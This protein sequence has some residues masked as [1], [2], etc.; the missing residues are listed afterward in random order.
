MK[1]GPALSKRLTCLYD[2]CVLAGEEAPYILCD[3]GC[4]HAHV[5]IRLLGSG[6]ITRAICMDVIPGPL[7]KAKEN[8]TL[9]GCED[10]ADLILSDGLQ[11]YPGGADV[12]L[13]SGMGG[14][15]MAQILLAEPEKVLSFRK[16]ILQPQSEFTALRKAL[17]QLSIRIEDEAMVEEEGKFYPVLYASPFKENESGAAALS[18]IELEYGPV[19]L[20]KKD[21]VLKR[22]LENGLLKIRRILQG[23]PADGKDEERASLLHTKEQIE[24][25][26]FL[27]SEKEG[28]GQ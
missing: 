7:Q 4:D 9:Y 11:Q 8:L 24:Q 18:D 26:L 10:G 6:V 23:F 2:F 17:E 5:P 19:L 13:I 27:V 12:L 20:K 22:Y 3:V 21:V 14:I 15:L 16:I 28:S 25:A 1:K